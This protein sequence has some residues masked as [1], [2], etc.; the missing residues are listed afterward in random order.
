MKKFPSLFFVGTCLFVLLITGIGCNSSE[1]ETEPM[2]PIDEPNDLLE[3]AFE[4]ENLTLE[5]PD[6]LGQ[7]EIPADNPMTVQ[8]VDLGRRLFFDPIL[9]ADSTMS[10]ST[11]H[12]PTESFS[13]GLAT[14]PGIDGIL[15]RRSTCLLYTSDA[16]DE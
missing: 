16:A 7:I 1:P 5:Y 15:G 12:N 6:W 2:G 14:S 13:D 4:P 10:C 11:C 3:F 9:S 8:G